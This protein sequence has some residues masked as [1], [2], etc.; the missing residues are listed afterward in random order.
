[1]LKEQIN[2]DYIQARKD[3]NKEVADTLRLLV[4]EIKNTE[5][6]KR[7]T[8]TDDEVIAMVKRQ[9][10]GANTLIDE[11]KGTDREA[12]GLAS[13]NAE[14]AILNK[15]LP[16]MLTI[17]QILE[18]LEDAGATTDMNMGQLMGIVMKD[19]KAEVDGA[20]VKTVVLENYINK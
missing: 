9:V 17:V 15:Y 14:I 8:V 12:E 6:D 13:A 3:K 19:H 18:I 1:M 5:I 20:L 10:K 16:T 11:T 2:K 7:D 4:T